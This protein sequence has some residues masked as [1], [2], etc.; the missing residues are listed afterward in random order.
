MNTGKGGGGKKGR[1]RS[2][3]GKVVA[4]NSSSAYTFTKLKALN[5][6]REAH[7]K[8]LEGWP[9][10]ELARWI[11]QD[12]SEY[13]DVSRDSLVSILSKYRNTIPAAEFVKTNENLSPA[14][15]DKL[16]EAQQGLDELAEMEKLYRLQMERVE[17]DRKM[18]QNIKKLLP[19]MGQEVRTAK[20]IL[21][22]YADLK[23]DLGITDR[24]L[25]TART[26]MIN[27]TIDLSGAT[28]AVQ[29]VLEDP[30]SRRKLSAIAQ[31]FLTAAK[32]PVTAKAD[33]EDAEIVE[34]AAEEILD[35]ELASFEGSSEGD[36][37]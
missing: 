12:N 30:E 24:N 17:I 27:A 2:R 31:R 16:R 13:N 37:E 20:E 25:G 8:L 34:G 22:A 21:Q 7:Q 3:G 18:E 28:P 15:A 1:S 11:Q 14:L 19:T 33:V 29:K 10:S 26:E 9:I 36:A 4:L 35:S 32:D 5:C 6:F 23:M